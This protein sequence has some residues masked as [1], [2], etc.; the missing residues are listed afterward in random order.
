MVRRR[1]SRTEPISPRVSRCVLRWE[2]RCVAR[3][4]VLGCDLENGCQRGVMK[5]D[6][7]WWRTE[8]RLTTTRLQRS[9]LDVACPSILPGHLRRCTENDGCNSA[10]AIPKIRAGVAA[11]VREVVAQPSASSGARGYGV[12]SGGPANGVVGDETLDHPFLWTSGGDPKVQGESGVPRECYGGLDTDESAGVV[13]EVPCHL[14]AASPGKPEERWEGAVH[15]EMR[16]CGIHRE[17]YSPEYPGGGAALCGIDGWAVDSGAKATRFEEAE[18]FGVRGGGVDEDEFLIGQILSV[19]SGPANDTEASAVVIALTGWRVDETEAL[20]QVR[21]KTCRCLCL[22]LC[23]C[24]SCSH[25]A[26]PGPY[27]EIMSS[28]RW[29]STMEFVKL[30]LRAR[31]HRNLC[32]LGQTQGEGWRQTAVNAWARVLSRQLRGQEYLAVCWSGVSPMAGIAMGLVLRLCPACCAFL[33]R[34]LRRA[35]FFCLPA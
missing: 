13:G 25:R 16:N 21:R 6:V 9:G 8:M 29:L 12:S 34:V 10:S 22:G 11:L 17:K 19:E 7:L 35:A 14:T 15:R 31:N 5:F 26:P 4:N 18:K 27:P 1:R 3:L 24:V 28:S 23:L 33:E 20:L 2:R 30:K 32:S